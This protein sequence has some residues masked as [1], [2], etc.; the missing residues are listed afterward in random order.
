M[1]AGGG[2]RVWV[3]IDVREEVA[4]A[5][6]GEARQ[7]DLAVRRAIRWG[8]PQVEVVELESTGAGEGVVP[9][10]AVVEVRGHRV[11]VLAVIGQRDAEALLALDEIGDAGGQQLVV[12]LLISIGDVFAGEPGCVLRLLD[13]VRFDEFGG[14]GQGSG[15][16]GADGGHG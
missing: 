11:S 14:P 1:L 9:P 13:L 12:F 2:S 6:V 3:S 10:S 16:R 15:M 5:S 7:D 8:V 4:V